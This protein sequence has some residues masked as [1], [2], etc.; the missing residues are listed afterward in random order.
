MNT[1][2]KIIF[3]TCLLLLEATLLQAQVGIGTTSPNSSAQLDVSSNTKG[4]LPPR[5]TTAE[6][7][8]IENPA[9]GL[10]IFNTTTS[11]LEIKTSSAWVKLVVP[12]D[13]VA[14][15]TGIVAVANG[16]TGVTTSTGTGN[17]VL[18]TSPLLTTPNLGTPS[19]LT[20]TNATGLPIS[21]GVSG[22]G[23]NVATF[24]GT[25]S[26][27]N[28]SSTVTDKTG[29]GTLVFGTSPTLTTPIISSTTN[30]SN[31]GAIRYNTSNNL[32]EFSN[33]SS[34]QSLSPGNSPMYAQFSSN[35]A[36]SFNI[37]G[38]KM[39]FQVTNINVGSMT[40]INNG[41]ISLPAGRIYRVDLNLGWALINNVGWSRFA[42]FNASS[43]A[44]LSQTAH[45]EGGTSN[46]IGTGTT[47]CFI[48]TS[49]GAINIEVRFV[50][51]VN[52]NSFF[53]D[54][55]NGASYPSLTIQTVD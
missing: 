27:A 40:N 47:T 45:I 54:S 23:S 32:I 6:R 1:T 8:T 13:N 46:F 2:I 3:A 24:L 11:G 35:A 9:T 15:V 34:W 39:L 7:N 25:P 50:A 44:Q 19:A 29:S 12:T 4:F 17:L 37:I 36:Q 53:G 51:P 22:L 21:S 48:N 31:A 16:G 38:T 41:S 18:S 52:A 28:L 30:T 10:I 33:G 55:V 49:S 5:M 20:L 26:S 42:I 43:G 14:N